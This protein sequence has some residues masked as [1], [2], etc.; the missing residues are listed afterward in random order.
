MYWRGI[1]IIRTFTAK[2]LVYNERRLGDVSFNLF[3]TLYNIYARKC[4]EAKGQI[5]KTYMETL[6]NK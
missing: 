5:C 2:Q 3:P 1:D 4:D 6:M